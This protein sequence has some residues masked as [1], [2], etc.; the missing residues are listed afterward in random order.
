MFEECI[1][2][3]IIDKISHGFLYLNFSEIDKFQQEKFEY[4]IT[5]SILFRRK[6]IKFVIE[7][8]IFEVNLTE[9]IN[10]EILKFKN[11]NKDINLN[12]FNMQ[13][14]CYLFKKLEVLSRTVKSLL[15]LLPIIKL[16]HGNSFDFYLDF[17]IN[18]KE[19]DFMSNNDDKLDNQSFS[20]KN[21][22]VG[23]LNKND[24][25]I[26]VK[27]DLNIFRMNSNKIKENQEFNKENTFFP[28]Q[29]QM[30]LIRTL[31]NS[32]KIFNNY[33]SLYTDKIGKIKLCIEY[34][35]K[36]DVF[37]IEENINKSISQLERI[38]KRKRFLSENGNDYYNQI[39]NNNHSKS[40]NSNKIKNDDSYNQTIYL[41]NL[42]N[43]FMVEEN[44]HDYK[45]SNLN[46]RFTEKNSDNTYPLNINELPQ[47]EANFALE[48]NNFLNSVANNKLNINQ[49]NNINNKCVKYF[50]NII[51]NCSINEK[52]IKNGFE[53]VDNGE[54]RINSKSEDKNNTKSNNNF[55]TLKRPNLIF[56]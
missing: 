3:K 48:D 52:V 15:N 14:K 26:G 40:G 4:C 34:L 27:D 45:S 33:R 55:L 19:I 39:I 46:L 49:D 47:K 32:K 53:L 54:K 24:D 36:H 2:N 20:A 43:S 23:N 28:I 44:N 18:Y 22:L 9:E 11:P 35:D 1:N 8:W 56:Y 16:F 17:E 12:S 50:E 21:I 42:Q 13:K 29:K 10:N 37:L 31:T 38:N 51:P 7:N 30:D 6:D 41:K 25:E 5:I